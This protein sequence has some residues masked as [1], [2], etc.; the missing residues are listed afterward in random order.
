MQCTYRISGNNLRV[1]RGL[2]SG[3]HVIALNQDLGSELDE[4]VTVT[5]A[6]KLQEN[7]WRDKVHHYQQR[8]PHVVHDERQ[9]KQALLGPYLEKAYTTLAMAVGTQ[10][11]ALVRHTS[12]VESSRR[13]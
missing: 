12:C 2:E 11:E 6:V 7:E 13:A 3:G 9:Q 4:I 10:D 8:S 1:V 5:I